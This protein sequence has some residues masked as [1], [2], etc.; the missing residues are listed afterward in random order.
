MKKIFFILICLVCIGIGAAIGTYID[1]RSYFT[2]PNFFSPLIV[3]EKPLP[4][5]K[6]SIPALQKQEYTSSVITVDKLIQ[7]Y[8]EFTSY[9]FSFVTLG[10]KMTGQLNVPK[11]SSAQNSAGFP[12][13]VLVRGYVPLSIYK[14]G[15]GTKNAA[16][17]F[18]KKGYLTVA[19]DFFGYGE[20]DPENSDTWEARFQ[21]PVE[22]VE[23]IKSIQAIPNLQVNNVPIKMNA[24]R[25]GIW[26]HSNGGQIALTSLEISQQPIPTTLWAPVTAPFP[27]SILYFTDEESDEGKN[28]RQWIAN[29]EESYNVFD[30]SLTQ[31]LDALHGPVQIQQGLN[32]EAIHFTWSQEF[33]D[34]LKAENKK[35]ESAMNSAT[36]S[37]EVTASASAQPIEVTFYSYPGTDHNMRPSW[38]TAIGRDVEFFSKEL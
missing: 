3:K 14:T 6:Y 35:R 1:L 9:Q 16:A 30:F 32:D 31:H 38:D 5:L 23:L 34:K 10:K 7:E 4:L 15:V 37:A 12:V 20:S 2:R 17:V 36:P 33:V 8:P 25:I 18:A 26:A 24:Q 28:S 22:V 21:K 13:I 29:F 19:P 11:V 27:Y